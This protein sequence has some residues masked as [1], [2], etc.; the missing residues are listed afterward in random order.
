M[1]DKKLTELDAITDATGDDII[2]IVD[3]P[4]GTPAQKKITIY[5]YLLRYP[6]DGRLTLESGVPISTS[7]Q[8]AKTTIYYTPYIGDVIAL[9]DGTYWSL[10]KFSEINIAVPASTSQMYDVFCYNDSGTA[11]LELLAWTNDTTRATELTRQNGVLVKNGDSTRRY[12]GSMRTTGISGETEDST[13]AR[14][15][16]N[17]YNRIH[18]VARKFDN[19]SHAYNSTTW[20]A[21][22]N[23]TGN[24]AEFIIGV[25]EDVIFTYV[26]G[27]I[28]NGRIGVRLDATSGTPAIQMIAS[29]FAQST[30]RDCRANPYLLGYHYICAM[31]YTSANQTLYAIDV[32]VEIYG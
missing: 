17:Y 20:R 15:V 7:D 29:A 6:A 26:I 9:H 18:N 25:M 5:D 24:I 21:W 1:V 31:E 32:G 12:L 10:I 3:D 27:D 8:T 4:G 19:S 30:S 2:Y 28:T 11:T 22:N 23:N 13:A 14:F 16:W